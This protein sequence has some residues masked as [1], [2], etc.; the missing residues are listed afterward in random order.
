MYCEDTCAP[1]NEH[2]SGHAYYTAAREFV[3]LCVRERRRHSEE[4][5]LR[6]AVEQACRTD[7]NSA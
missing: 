1:A 2:G 3:T 5:P 4:T 7:L 6:T